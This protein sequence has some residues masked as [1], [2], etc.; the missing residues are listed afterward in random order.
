[1]FGPSPHHEQIGKGVRSERC[2]GRFGS[3]CVTNPTLLH[4]QP[5]F[6][7]FVSAAGG[8]AVGINGESTGW[9]GGAAW[10]HLVA[11]QWPHHLCWLPAVGLEHRC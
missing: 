5:R 9:D 11:Q 10:V 6:G 4:P 3:S 2:Q 1:M 7:T 8:G